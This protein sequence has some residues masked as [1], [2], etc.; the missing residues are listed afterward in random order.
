M[1]LTQQQIDQCTKR[2]LLCEICGKSVRKRVV[3]AG[4]QYMLY[5][6]PVIGGWQKPTLKLHGICGKCSDTFGK[7]FK[8]LVMRIRRERKK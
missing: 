5:F 2:K 7:R 8:A 1:T 4:E 3:K 6:E